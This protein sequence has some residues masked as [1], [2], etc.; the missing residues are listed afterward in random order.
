MTHTRKLFAIAALALVGLTS[1]SMFKVAH[2]YY[3]YSDGHASGV[4]HGSCR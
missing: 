4:Y 2:A 3:C 1:T